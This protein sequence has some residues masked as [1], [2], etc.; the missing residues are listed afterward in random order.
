MFDG[1]VASLAVIYFMLKRR[2]FLSVAEKIENDL[3]MLEI[4]KAV[5]NG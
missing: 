1:F 4:L 2:K 3:G 5:K